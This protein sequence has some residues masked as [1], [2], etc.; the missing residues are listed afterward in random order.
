MDT[1][2]RQGTLACGTLFTLLVLSHRGNVIIETK[3]FDDD[4]LVS[5]SKVRLF[6]V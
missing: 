5:T 6:Y 1:I 3:F 4:L 2:C